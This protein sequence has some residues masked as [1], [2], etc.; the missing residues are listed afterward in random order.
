MDWSYILLIAITFSLLLIIAQ[1]M[2]ERRRRLMRGFIVSM[3]I[4]LMIRYELHLENVIGYMIALIMSYLF[5]LLIGRYNPVG[6]GDDAIKVFGL[7]D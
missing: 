5:W 3:A 4:L 7:D 6:E 1:R 2:I